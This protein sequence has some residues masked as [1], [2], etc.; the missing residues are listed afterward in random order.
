MLACNIKTERKMAVKECACPPP[1]ALFTVFVQSLTPFQNTVQAEGILQKNLSSRNTTQTPAPSTSTDRPGLVGNFASLIQ[2]S[3]LGCLANY[4]SGC[5][6][7]L[8]VLVRRFHAPDHPHRYLRHLA[9]LSV[10]V[11]GDRHSLELEPRHHYHHGTLRNAAQM[12]SH[13]PAS[14][15]HPPCKSDRFDDEL[16]TMAY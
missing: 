4:L 13:V 9:V 11:C 3:E 16:S 6:W 5:P 2:D 8:M 10:Q 7:A 1:G 15:R 12:A 14:V